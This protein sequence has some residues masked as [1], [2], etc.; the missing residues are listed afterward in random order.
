MKLMS[1]RGS[2]YYT[3]PNVTINGGDGQATATA[4]IRMTNPAVRWV[5]L[6]RLMGNTKLDLS[7]ITS[8]PPK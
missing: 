6:H 4:F 7:F 2:N 5:F 1:N 3:A 8:I